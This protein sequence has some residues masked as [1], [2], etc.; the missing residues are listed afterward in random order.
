MAPRAK[1]KA[2]TTSKAAGKP[3]PDAFDVITPPN[4]LKVKVGGGSAPFDEDAIA[5][6]DAILKDLAENFREWLRDDIERL[7]E[8][9]AALQKSDGSATTR[10]AL[11]QVAH[12]LKG[13][14]ATLGLP[15]LGRVAG[16]LC[17]LVGEKTTSA[18]ALLADHIALIDTLFENGP[19][20]EAA[21]LG[22]A[23]AL[24]RAVSKLQTM[25]ASS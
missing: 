23:D 20:S 10:A 21:N 15:L 22:K 12:D 13:E 17:V 25:I 24:E 14:A 11:H 18:P 4:V 8:A 2:K 1:S 3:A 9:H 5:R 16:S 19:E 6:A 7:H